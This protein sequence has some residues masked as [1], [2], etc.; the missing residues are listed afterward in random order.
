MKPS[1]VALTAFSIFSCLLP[2]NAFA[3]GLGS[4]FETVKIEAQ[5]FVDGWDIYQYKRSSVRVSG[6]T[7]SYE[8]RYLDYNRFSWQ[9]AQRLRIWIQ[10]LLVFRGHYHLDGLAES[11][12]TIYCSERNFSSVGTRGVNILHPKETQY[13]YTG[14]R[15][16]VANYNANR[17]WPIGHTPYWWG[18]GGSTYT[19]S[20][21]PD[22]AIGIIASRHCP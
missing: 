2:S 21:T 1:V 9:D 4:E 11:R 19:G 5:Q 7:V 20:F 3:S 14:P 17:H 18:P 22:S 10:P 15:D 12:H 16:S 6:R 8:F 13:S